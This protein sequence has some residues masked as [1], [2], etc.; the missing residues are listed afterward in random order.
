M[1]GPGSILP[2]A[3]RVWVFGRHQYLVGPPQTFAKTAKGSLVLNFFLLLSRDS[4]FNGFKVETSREDLSLCSNL[5]GLHG[6]LQA[7]PNCLTVQLL[8]LFDNPKKIVIPLP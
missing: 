2:C 5:T 3:E 1:E 4:C 7:T 6:G 8:D